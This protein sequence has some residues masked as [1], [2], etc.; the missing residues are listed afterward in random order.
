MER[1]TFWGGL[2]DSEF[3]WQTN[4]E[5]AADVIDSKKSKVQ[6][7]GLAKPVIE[8]LLPIGCEDDP[9]DADEDSPSRVGRAGRFF[10]FLILS[11]HQLD[12]WRSDVSIP[13]LKPFPLSRSFLSSPPNSKSTCRQATL[14]CV[15]LRSWLSESPSKVAASLSAPTLISCGRPLKAVCKTRRSLSAV[16]LV[17]P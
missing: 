14:G 4:A 1:S 3:S 9:E 2:S 12:S 16:Q 17:S 8:G 10:S 13:S 5:E 15:N 6:A 11:A 7:L